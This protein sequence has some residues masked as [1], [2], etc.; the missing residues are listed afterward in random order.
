MSYIVKQKIGKNI[1]AYEAVSYYDKKKKQPR[2]KRNYLGRVN[3]ETNEIVRTD[4][5]SANMP[6]S[7]RCFGLVHLLESMGKSIGLRK[8][9]EE[10]FPNE[11]NKILSL[12][13]FELP[14]GKPCMLHWIE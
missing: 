11:W 9:L 6:K 12:S 10:A 4:R 8:A 13:F 2:Q 5:M 3:P 1:Y 14:E 7:V